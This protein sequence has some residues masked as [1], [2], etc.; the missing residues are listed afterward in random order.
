MTSR[1]L[2]G[3]EGVTDQ[4]VGPQSPPL[5]GEGLEQFHGFQTLFQSSNKNPPKGTASNPAGQS[6]GQTPGPQ[7]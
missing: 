5:E 3:R 7:A 2:T 4:R 1:R 6:E